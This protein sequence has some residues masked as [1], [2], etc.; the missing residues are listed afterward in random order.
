MAAIF[1]LHA[2]QQVAQ[3]GGILAHSA[4]QYCGVVIGLVFEAATG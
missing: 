2:F 4:Y 3:R 1:L